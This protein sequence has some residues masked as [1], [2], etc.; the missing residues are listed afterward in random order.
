MGKLLINAAYIIAALV[1]VML[2]LLYTANPILKHKQEHI[3]IQTEIGI[4]DVPLDAADIFLTQTRTH[5]IDIYKS[6]MCRDAEKIAEYADHAAENLETF[7]GT[8]VHLTDKDMYDM[9][10]QA[11]ADD[12]ILSEKVARVIYALDAARKSIAYGN[13]KRLNMKNV[14]I[15]M[16]NMNT[17]GDFY[18][19]PSTGIEV[20]LSLDLPRNKDMH[21][22][23]RNSVVTASRNE[24][25]SDLTP[26]YSAHVDGYDA[27]SQER[28]VVPSCLDKRELVSQDFVCPPE[29]DY[30]LTSKNSQP[31]VPFCD[32]NEMRAEREKKLNLTTD[33]TFNRSL[34]SD[35]DYLDQ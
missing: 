29:R 11:T 3:L 14:H 28:I 33:R 23:R 24:T 13:R 4:F 5:V 16:A 21:V 12:D 22:A 35:Y 1:V 7:V 18:Q 26:L 6:G 8:K 15:M 2:V 31:F 30:I 25:V 27:K 32:I 20:L 9:R 17:T 10:L 19:Q 34:R